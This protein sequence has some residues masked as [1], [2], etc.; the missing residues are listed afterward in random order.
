MSDIFDQLTEKFT[1]DADFKKRRELEALRNL[2]Y[3]ICGDVYGALVY[4]SLARGGI[5]SI[6]A[7]YETD[8]DD[9]SKIRNMGDVR[10][11]WVKELRNVIQ[12]ELRTMKF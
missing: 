3:Q 6:R 1:S 8:I 9:I 2:C 11:H 7:L 4:N 10:M 5:T 12:K